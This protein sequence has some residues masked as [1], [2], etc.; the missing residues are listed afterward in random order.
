MEENPGVTPMLETRIFNSFFGTVS[1]TIC[2]TWPMSLSV[3][4]R[5]VPVGALR[6]MTNWLGSVRGKYARP[7]S[8]YNPRLR[9]KIPVM[10]NTV[11]MGRSRLLFNVPS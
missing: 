5:R 10:P 1:R 3:T 11:A 4:S 9:T 8:G 6:L 2:S 7:T